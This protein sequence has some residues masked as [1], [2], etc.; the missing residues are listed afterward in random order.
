M[1]EDRGW[2]IANDL[3]SFDPRSSILDPRSSILDPRSSTLSGRRAAPQKIEDRLNHVVERS[4]L[5]DAEIRAGTDPRRNFI[6]AVAGDDDD[7]NLAQDAIG[8]KFSEHPLAV[9]VRQVQIENYDVGREAPRRAIAG[10]AAGR[11]PRFSALGFE[12]MFDRFARIFIVLDDQ[13]AGLVFHHRFDLLTVTESQSR[14]SGPSK[15]ATTDILLSPCSKFK[16]AREAPSSFVICHLSFVICHLP[17]EE[18]HIP[19]NGGQRSAF[20]VFWSK[21]RTATRFSESSKA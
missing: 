18:V 2:K 1:I 20:V 16:K 5:G 7:R 9:D 12:Q 4:R 15:R 8:A 14:F 3:I 17:F 13:D 11:R 6:A 21:H 10:D 19:K